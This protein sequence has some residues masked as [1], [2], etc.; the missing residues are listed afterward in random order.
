[1]LLAGCTPD[2]VPT[3]TESVGPPVEVTVDWE[4][5]PSVALESDAWVVAARASDAGYRAASNALDFTIDDFVGTRT[6]QLARFQFTAWKANADPVVYAGPSI[7]VPLAVEVA[8]SGT[9]ATLTFCEASS[10]DWVITADG[11]PAYTLTSGRLT[12]LRM[13]TSDSG[14]LV[15]DDRIPSTEKCDPAGAAVGRFDPVPEPRASVDP[16]DARPYEG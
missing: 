1:V 14:A 5:A 6:A 13:V 10:A 9:E 3:P 11:E 16:D 4:A 15:L 8:A 7:M 2:P 12:E